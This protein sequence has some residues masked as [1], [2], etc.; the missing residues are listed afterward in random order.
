MVCRSERKFL[1]DVTH[2]GA[3]SISAHSPAT[4]PQHRNDPNMIKF[5]TLRSV[6]Y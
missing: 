1:T 5:K 2:V 4:I 3:D 6:V